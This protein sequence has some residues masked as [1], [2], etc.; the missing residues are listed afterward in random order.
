MACRELFEFAL[1]F[2]R[3]NINGPLHFQTGMLF[4]TLQAFGAMARFPDPRQNR[5]SPPATSHG[6]NVQ[7]QQGSGDQGKTPRAPALGGAS[8][9]KHGAG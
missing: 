8:A 6:K 5:A 4:E 3:L 1:L 7:L 9:L 2:N